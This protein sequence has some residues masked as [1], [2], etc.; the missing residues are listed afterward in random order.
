MLGSGNDIESPTDFNDCV[1]KAEL[2]KFADDQHTFMTEKF[3]EMMCHINNPVN[4]VEHV[5]QRP[6]PAREDDDRDADR[7]CRNRY[8]MRGNHNCGNN[9]PFA[10][11]KF[12][13]IPFAGTTDP[14]EY[15]NWELAV[16][17][18]FNSYLV[19]AKHRFRLATIE[20][21]SFALFWWNDLCTNGNA[22]A[23]PQT[24]NILKQHMK[25]RFV[26]PY[27]QRD[28]RLKL[29]TLTQ[30]HKGVEEY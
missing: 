28:L 8:G 16:E 15:L 24:W 3:D 12:T 27:Y 30:G 1:S 5:E 6:P 18:K 13:M 22:A 26:P 2:Q 4:W 10:K 9:D 19:P 17:Q 7:L 29:Q 23:V 21:T 14:E 11:A 20:F 25:S